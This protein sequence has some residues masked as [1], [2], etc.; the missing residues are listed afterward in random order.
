MFGLPGG[1]V[2]LLGELDH[3]PRRGCAAVPAGE[4]AGEPIGFG[5]DLDPPRRPR[6]QQVGGDAD[7]LPD[8][9]PVGRSLHRQEPGA[10]PCGEFGFEVG[11][12]VLTDRD[13]RPIQR[14]PVQGEPGPVGAVLDLVRD[15]H[16]GVQ[17]R[18]AVAGIAMGERG[19]DDPGH[20]GLP[21]PLGAA[22]GVRHLG[23]EPAEGVVDGGLVRGLDL[24]GDRPWRDRPQRADALHRGE[25][26]V[27]PGDGLRRPAGLPGHPAGQ[28]LRVGGRSAVLVL[29][30]LPSD[31]GPDPGPHLLRH[32]MVQ[33][34]PEFGVVGLVGALDLDQERGRL[35]RRHRIRT[36]ELGGLQRV[37]HRVAGGDRRLLQRVGVRMPT[38]PEQGPHLR[39]GHLIAHPD[40]AQSGDAV[41]DPPARPFTLLGVVVG[42]RGPA[43]LGRVG[44]RDL[45]GQVRVPVPSG[46]LVQTRSHHL[47][48]R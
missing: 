40:R 25:R 41:A 36:A 5:F 3:L 11:V 28:F 4:L 8:R 21:D 1:E 39:L 33:P 18:V 47:T 7:D 32:R 30:R 26:D 17:V 22:A 10:E 15:R 31:H 19:R 20:L 45:P 43:A 13:H 16:V 34:Q 12:V 35:P 42:Q 37:P 44:D 29:E 38:L 2:G 9:P 24:F 14:G 46:Q 27:E 6:L 48:V 23:L